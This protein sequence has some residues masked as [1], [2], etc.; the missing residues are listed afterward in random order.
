MDYYKEQFIKFLLD[1][2]ALKFGDFTLKSGR[3]S[4]FFMNMGKLN[5]GNQLIEL[6]T[7]Y[8]EAISDNFGRDIDVVFGP[9]YK[10]I[11]LAVATAIQFQQIFGRK[12]RH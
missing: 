6:G 9:A 12:I 1:S 7:A 2:D 5:D 10:G 8:A 4:P 11:P 3:K